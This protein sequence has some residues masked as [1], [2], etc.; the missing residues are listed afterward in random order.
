MSLLLQI[1]PR[2]NS[3]L[4]GQYRWYF[5]QAGTETAVGYLEAFY[6]T[7]EK[8]AKFPK[9]GRACRFPQRRFKDFRSLAIDAPYGLYSIYYRVSP[10]HLIVE[11]VMHSSRDLPRR[12]LREEA[13]VYGAAPAGTGVAQP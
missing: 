2:A 9:L 11:R 3:D 6:A 12:L 10:T 8:L 13:A 1:S 7:A 4:A 5:Q